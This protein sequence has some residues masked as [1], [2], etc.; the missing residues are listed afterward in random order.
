GVFRTQDGGAS[1]QRIQVPTS[2]RIGDIAAASERVVWTS[3]S[4][5]V[6][7]Y[8]RDGGDSWEQRRVAGKVTSAPPTAT[9]IIPGGPGVAGP[10]LADFSAVGPATESTAWVVYGYGTIVRT[11]DAGQSWEVQRWH[12]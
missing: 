8:S 6:L 5:G 11:T 9:P 4:E 2:A 1:W 3:S 12:S 10:E 7:L